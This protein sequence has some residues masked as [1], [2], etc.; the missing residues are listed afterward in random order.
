[1]P[2][3]YAETA[4]KQA[5][6][7]PSFAG[8]VALAPDYV[9]QVCRWL[10]P[11]KFSNEVIGKFWGKVLDGRDPM[12]VAG[13]LNILPDLLKWINSTNSFQNADQFARAIAQ[14]YYLRQVTLGAQDLAKAVASGDTDTIAGVVS[15]LGMLDDGVEVDMRDVTEVGENL[16]DR[17]TS[18]NISMKFGIDSVDIATGG[19]ERGTMTVIAARPS[20]G[21]TALALEFAENQALLQGKK[22]AFFALEMTAEQLMARR[23]CHKVNNKQGYP[24]SWQDVRSENISETETL[25]LFDEID[26]YAEKIKGKL[27][28]NDKTKTTSADIIK[29]QA[30]ERYDVI[31][32]D[33]LGLLKDKLQGNERTD[34]R[35]GRITMALHELAKD[36]D[37][38]VYLLHQLNRGTE[39]RADHRP[40][41]GDLRDSGEI[42]QNADNVILLYRDSYYNGGAEE[43][44]PMELIIGKYRDGARLSNCYVGYDLRRQRFIS[45]YAED[46]NK[47]AEDAMEDTYAQQ[48]FPEPDD[49]P[50]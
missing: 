17:I 12:E 16:K 7:E 10:E 11:A 38:V 21:K 27:F 47:V 34:Q 40:N 20:M 15:A 3:L 9:R 44:D 18:G 4:S 35:L 22:V 24:A 23:V 46:L 45:V 30:K 39:G 14:K 50:F 13:E 42:E 19:S 31:Y 26:K 2:D 32:I 29:A 5:Q 33:H 36:Y 49:I 1:M 41:M 43:V 28:I 6:I 37:C 25:K 48:Q 8:C